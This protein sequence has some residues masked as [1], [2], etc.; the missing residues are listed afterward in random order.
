MDKDSSLEVRIDTLQ[1]LLTKLTNK[2]CKYAIDVYGYI[3]DEIERL[4]NK[5]SRTSYTTSSSTNVTFTGND[6]HDNS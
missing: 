2:R 5:Q 4:A 6:K 3:S 1:Q